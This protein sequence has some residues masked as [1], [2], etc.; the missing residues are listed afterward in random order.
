L[1]QI[2]TGNVELSGKHSVALTDVTLL[3]HDP[4][5]PIKFK[6]EDQTE[7]L[8]VI[9]IK[10]LS[11]TNLLFLANNFREAELLL[12]GLKLLLERETARLGVRGGVPLASFGGRLQMQGAMSP[13]AARGVEDSPTA[14]SAARRRGQGRGRG[15]KASSVASSKRSG[16]SSSEMDDV[17][18]SVGDVS[19]PQENAVPEGW[20]SWGRV[21]GRNYMRGQAASYDSTGNADE[22]VPKYVHG[23]LLVRDICKNVRLPL[24]LPL[25]RVLLL[26]SSSPVITKWEQDRGDRGFEKTPWTF[27]PATPREKEHYQSEHQLI[28]SG[29]MC[30]AHRTTSYERPRNGTL[31]RLSET[32]IVD[33]DDSEKLSF[34]V[35]ERMPRRG[36]SIKVRVVLRSY[37]TSSCDATILGEIRP[38]GKNM[39]NQAAVHRAFLLVVDELRQRYGIDGVGLMGGFLSVVESMQTGGEKPAPHVVTPT[40]LSRPYR[41]TGPPMIEEKKENDVSSKAT[42]SIDSSG[43]VSFEDMLKR[44]AIPNDPTEPVFT[45]DRP[46]TP[47]IHLQALEPDQGKRIRS[48]KRETNDDLFENLEE[49][50]KREPVMIEVKPLPKIRLSLMPSPREEDEAEVDEESNQSPVR[51]TVTKPSTNKKKKKSSHSPSSGWRKSSKARR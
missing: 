23:Q 46:S 2:R 14:G 37:T 7:H 22:G 20:R 5:V 34:T 18:E 32:Q 13:A 3:S 43:L 17:D 8:R 28:A 11:G 16:Y 42:S 44:D 38:V 26:D 31:V 47:S 1:G 29:S 21:P 51:N 39:S 4:P 10:D 35:S 41:R 49:E 6:H 25:C 33:S 9:S 30:G 27:P 19:S 45:H 12:C 50:T 48:R 36:F 15:G 40:T 24:P